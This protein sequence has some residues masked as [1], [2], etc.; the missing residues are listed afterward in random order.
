MT[1]KTHKLCKWNEALKQTYNN[2]NNP[3]DM[4]MLG[5]VFSLDNFSEGGI[6]VGHCI[7]RQSVVPQQRGVVSPSKL[8]DYM[9][10]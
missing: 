1:D 8:L 4:F 7:K 5:P 3:L 9:N 2:F 6:E 10:I